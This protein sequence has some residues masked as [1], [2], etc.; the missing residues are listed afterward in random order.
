M[1]YLHKYRFLQISL[2][3][4]SNKIKHLEFIQSVINRLNS[5][6]FLIKGWSVTLVSALFALSKNNSDINFAL[7]SYIA[8][9]TFWILDGYY[10]SMERKFR[11]MYDSIRNI[12]EDKID[13]EINPKKFNTNKN[14][15]IYSIFS[16]SF[17]WFY[18]LLI[19]ITI[20]IMLIIQ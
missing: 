5:N 20:I 13:F 17:L 3:N 9:P 7:I 8:I 15:W 2:K 4:M 6:S 11:D 1:A 19:G 16:I 14:S 12:S 10:L 18:L